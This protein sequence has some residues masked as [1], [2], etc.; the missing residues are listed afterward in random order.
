MP[1]IWLA[2][3]ILLF[4]RFEEEHS[5]ASAHLIHLPVDPALREMMLGARSL[6][7]VDDEASTGKTFINLYQALVEAGLSNIERVVTCVLTDWSA[8]AVST[9]MGAVAEQVSL[10]QG[11]YSFD[12]DV[13]APLPDMP[14]V[15]TVAMGDWPLVTAN[16]WG[17]M[18]VLSV[19]DTLAPG[20]TV[21]KGERV[22]V[23]GTS[24]FVWRPFLL[25]ERL[26]KAGA[27]VHFSSTSRSPIALGH[28]IDHALS[29][30]DNYG[31]GIPNFLYNV[32]P[33]QFDRVLIC[34]E[35]PRQAV[36]AE[37]IEALNAEVICDE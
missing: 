17:R 21:Q 23:V 9:S 35:T 31:L 29:F 33:G 15:G 19:A 3:A 4:A 12:E 20:L 32:R 24:E 37:L 26:E 16:D 11:S 14:E 5:H 34:T 7:L 8:G 13:S 30:S 18:G 28:A 10:L 25:A 22:L 6:V 27:D 1:C 2:R 36:P